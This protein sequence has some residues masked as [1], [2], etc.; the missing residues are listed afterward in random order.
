MTQ[1]CLSATQIWDNIALRNIKSEVLWH[2]VSDKET[3][4]WLKDWSKI[5]V[6]VVNHIGPDVLK[7]LFVAWHS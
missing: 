5:S 3:Q 1:W 7:Q 4:D 6:C 2:S